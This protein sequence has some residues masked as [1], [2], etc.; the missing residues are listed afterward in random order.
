M[1]KKDY[2]EARTYLGIWIK[3]FKLKKENPD[4]EV[5]NVFRSGCRYTKRHG[6]CA[7]V[8]YTEKVLVAE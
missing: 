6:W 2:L 7:F 1:I 8:Q 4:L 5:N 3:I